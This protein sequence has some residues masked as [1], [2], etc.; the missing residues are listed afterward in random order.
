MAAYKSF[1][2]NKIL[3]IN[4]FICVI[5]F[6]ETAE[7]VKGDAFSFKEVEMAA[8]RIYGV[9]FEVFGKVQGVFFRKHTE[10]QAKVFGLRG[11]CMNTSQGTVRG[12]LEGDQ[13]KI[14]EMKYWLENKGSPTSRI[15]KAVFSEIKE[16]P[17]YSYKGFTIKR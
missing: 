12:K 8:K 17:D 10:K 9:D 2:F 4:I 1:A 7:S 13:D 6:P 5:S 11:W 16:I 14:N 15:D 3:F